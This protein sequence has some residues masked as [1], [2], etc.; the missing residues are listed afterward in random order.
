MDCIGEKIGTPEAIFSDLRMLG[1]LN[2]IRGIGRHI[3]YTFD[4]NSFEESDLKLF[5]DD[6]KAFDVKCLEDLFLIC[7][8]V[9]QEKSQL[10]IWVDTDADANP[11]S[12]DIYD[13]EFGILDVTKFKTEFLDFFSAESDFIQS[14]LHEWNEDEERGQNEISFTTEDLDLN[15]LTEKGSELLDEVKELSKLSPWHTSLKKFINKVL[16][17]Y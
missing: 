10:V 15:F 8:V 4:M 2:R 7:C 6:E 16:A 1:V 14:E 3:F 13:D 9:Q 17:D 5:L 12:I 11:I